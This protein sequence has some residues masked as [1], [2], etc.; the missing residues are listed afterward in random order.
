MSCKICSVD[1]HMGYYC[2]ISTGLPMSPRLYIDCFQ[3]YM[4]L[5]EIAQALHNMIL[6]VTRYRI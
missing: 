1:Q 4:E 3:R 2:T 6:A 5:L